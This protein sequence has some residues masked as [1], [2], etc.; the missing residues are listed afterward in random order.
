MREVRALAEAGTTVV[1]VEHDLDVIWELCDEVAFMAEG[2]LLMKGSPEMIRNDA[3]VV[4]KYLG[5]GHA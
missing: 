1:I 2:R 5:A 3:T 4:E